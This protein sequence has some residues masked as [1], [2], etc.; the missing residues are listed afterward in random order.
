MNIYH[1]INHANGEKLK[2]FVGKWDIPDEEWE[3]IEAELKRI[4]AANSF[5]VEFD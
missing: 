4:R 3:K 2:Q 1:S 5:P